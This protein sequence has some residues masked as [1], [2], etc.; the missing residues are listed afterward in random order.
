MVSLSL[1]EL[2]LAHIT[3]IRGV[4]AQVFHC[5][6]LLAFP[7]VYKVSHVLLYPATQ[8]GLLAWGRLALKLPGALQPYC[9]AC[10]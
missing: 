5:K 9:S 8:D 7:P 3:V 1:Q 10:E 4:T 2:S 6:T